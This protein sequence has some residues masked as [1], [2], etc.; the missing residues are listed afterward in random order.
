[1]SIKTEGT[2]NRKSRLLLLFF[3]IFFGCLQTAARMLAATAE[4]MKSPESA[5]D[6]KI[7]HLFALKK[8]FIYIKSPFENTEYFFLDGGIILLKNAFVYSKII[9]KNYSFPEN[10]H[11]RKCRTK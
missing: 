7:S 10:K 1:M 11:C 9:T 4:A 3:L 5:K 6:E 8:R 2:D